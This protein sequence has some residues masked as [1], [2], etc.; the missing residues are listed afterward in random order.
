M[1]SD[2]LFL[3][4]WEMKCVVIGGCHSRGWRAD[5]ER[6]RWNS[7]YQPVFTLIHLWTLEI[8]LPHYIRLKFRSKVN[9]GVLQ[10]EK[11]KVVRT[12]MC[13]LIPAHLYS[14]C[15]NSF[16]L[17][18][19][20]KRYYQSSPFHIWGNWSP[21]RLGNLPKVTHILST[22]GILF[23]APESLYRDFFNTVP[24]PRGLWKRIKNNKKR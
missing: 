23:Q 1:V 9:Y 12:N 22:V 15:A 10:S 14:T 20:P 5:N 21:M 6:E 19:P 17:H 3:I 8:L 7:F 24:L 11:K 2:I 16:H 13:S 4:Q 18:N